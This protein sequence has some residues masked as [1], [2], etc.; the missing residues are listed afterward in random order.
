MSYSVIDR[1]YLKGGRYLSSATMEY[2]FPIGIANSRMAVF[3]DAG[4]S[5]DDYKDENASMVQV[6][7]IVICQSMV[8]LV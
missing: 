8:Q 6:L 1:G 2:Q 4:T 7:A 5:C 3:L